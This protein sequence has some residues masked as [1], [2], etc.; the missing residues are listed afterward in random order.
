MHLKV[1]C[2]RVL[3]IRRSLYQPGMCYG[4]LMTL[5][6]MCTQLYKMFPLK[7]KSLKKTFQQH[8]NSVPLLLGDRV[9][10]ICPIPT[11]DSEEFGPH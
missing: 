11:G 5:A 10:E 9:C 8:C 2:T 1:V 6:F 4:M 3:A 7:K